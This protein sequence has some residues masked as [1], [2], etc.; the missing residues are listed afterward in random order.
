MC[1]FGGHSVARGWSPLRE[2]DTVVGLADLVR[3]AQPDAVAESEIAAS[4][5]PIVHTDLG[6]P[7]ALTAGIWG[8]HRD[9]S[10]ADH[11]RITTEPQHFLNFLPDPHGHC[12]FR[13]I[14]PPVA[15]A[16]LSRASR[17]APPRA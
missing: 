5:C 4:S 6:P 8:E 2:I 13:P 15:M 11:L 16:F 9:V 7:D 12:S 14:R 3:A 1:D 17:K 10:A